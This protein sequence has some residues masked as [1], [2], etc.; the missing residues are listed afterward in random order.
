M[1]EDGINGYLVE[2]GNVDQLAKFINM[3]LSKHEHEKQF[4]EKSLE[5]A[6]EFSYDNF[7]ENWQNLFNEVKTQKD[8]FAPSVKLTNV[9]LENGIYQLTTRVELKAS[10]I[11]HQTL[12]FYL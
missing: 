7:V 5:K 4:S 10:K 8:V 2:E 1:I 6:Q 11:H 9:D 3:Y 12:S